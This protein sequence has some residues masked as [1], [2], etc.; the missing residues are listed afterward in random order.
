MATTE[1]SADGA[2]VGADNIKSGN[3]NRIFRRYT[4]YS[5][6]ITDG[7]LVGTIQF[8]PYLEPHASAW[9][10]GNFSRCLL[11]HPQPLVLDPRLAQRRQ[12]GVGG[13]PQLQKRVVTVLGS[14]SV[15]GKRSRSPETE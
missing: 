3:K 13:I 15:S 7:L 8:S 1:P 2:T 5:R 6:L 10:A 11:A 9:R 12:V 4:V 14:R